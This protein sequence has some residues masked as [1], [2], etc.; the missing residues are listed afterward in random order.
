MRKKRSEGAKLDRDLLEASAHHS[1][2]LDKRLDRLITSAAVCKIFGFTRA[3][4]S[5]AL[6]KNQVLP[7]LKMQG[8]GHVFRVWTLEVCF[9]GGLHDETFDS[10]MSQIDVMKITITPSGYR[11]VILKAMFVHP[12]PIMEEMR[13]DE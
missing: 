13:N 8:V 12:A 1:R 3:N 2:E 6:K 9:G 5:D 4:L 7:R 11:G 10:R